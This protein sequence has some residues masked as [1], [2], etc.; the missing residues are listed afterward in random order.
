V[1]LAERCSAL[2]VAGGA[3]NVGLLAELEGS[4]LATFGGAF[5]KHIAQ[6]EFLTDNETS[7]I[8]N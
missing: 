1:N 5:A 4:F 7:E 3:R 2:R 8:R 6:S